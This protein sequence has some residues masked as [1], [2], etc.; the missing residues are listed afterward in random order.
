VGQDVRGDTA[1]GVGAEAAD[2]GGDAL[3]WH[4]SLN[5][6]ISLTVPSGRVTRWKWPLL[7]KFGMGPRL[8]T[9][10]DP[11]EWKDWRSPG[12]LTMKTSVFVK[13]TE[14]RGALWP[15][16]R[17]H[18]N[19]HERLTAGPMIGP[20]A[21]VPPPPV[22]RILGKVVRELPRRDRQTTLPIPLR[23]R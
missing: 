21:D 23:A 1:G 5:F 10:I 17:P 22:N 8:M 4:S 11:M 3:Y 14:Y 9:L 15:P 2:R 18:P 6:N 20:V 12:P 19:L 16:E 13:V 7:L